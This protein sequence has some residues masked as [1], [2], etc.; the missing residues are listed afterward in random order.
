MYGATE[1]SARLSYLEPGRFEEKMG[2]IGK[3]IPG[4]NLRVLGREKGEVSIGHTGELVGQG[5]NIMLG[6]WKDDKGT[7]KVLDEHGYYTGDLGYQDAD[8]YFYVTGRKDNLLKVGGHR[9]NPQEVEDALMGTQL[10]IEAVVLGQ[11]DALLGHR[12]VA[13]ACPKNGDC[14]E[15]LILSECSKRLP[16]Y[17]V[18]SEVKLLRSLPKNTNGKID[19]A[20]CLELFLSGED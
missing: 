2:S 10:A 15:S 1:A 8:G 18:P 5:P 9:I 11:P 6:Y 17:K 12:L 13:L 14:N 20:R 7:A 19:R 16:R 3:P 4:V